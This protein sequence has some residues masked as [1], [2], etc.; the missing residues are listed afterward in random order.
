MAAVVVQQMR[1]GTQLLSSNFQFEIIRDP[2]NSGPLSSAGI[3]CWETETQPCEIPGL[4]CF[5]TIGDESI[6][7]SS[8]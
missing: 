5:L 8:W 6:F 2:F 7:S 1:K 4:N 3:G